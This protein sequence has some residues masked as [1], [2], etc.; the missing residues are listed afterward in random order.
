MKSIALV[1]TLVVAFC[2]PT[3]AQS[4]SLDDQI[5]SYFG[6][7]GTVQQYAEAYDGMFTLI[8]NQFS[9]QEVPA[10][11]WDSLKAAK[12]D[13]LGEIV[14][15]LTAVYRKYFNASDIARMSEHFSLEGAA[16]E[17]DKSNFLNSEAGQKMIKVQN[18]LVT[19]IGQTSEYWSRDLYLKTIETLKENGFTIKQ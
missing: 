9:D 13:D 15:M 14:G 11:L 6:V 7:N 1:I 8:Q 2:C 12:S 18:A 4:D 10:A 5:R 17:A 3:Q 19:D 16:R